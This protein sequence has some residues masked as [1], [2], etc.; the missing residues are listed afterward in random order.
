MSIS[1]SNRAGEVKARGSGVILR[2][3]GTILTNYHVVEGGVFFDIRVSGS[4]GKALMLPARPAGCSPE[5]DL[6]TL[7]VTPPSVAL[8]VVQVRSH[9]RRAGHEVLRVPTSNRLPWV[10]GV[11]PRR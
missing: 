7:Q 10:I 1:V 5:D 2:S 11:R 3:D 8:K 9:S 4:H 6:A